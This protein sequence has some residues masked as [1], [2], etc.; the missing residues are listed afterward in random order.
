MNSKRWLRKKILWD[1]VSLRLRRILVPGVGPLDMG[2]ILVHIDP[3]LEHERRSHL[4]GLSYLPLAE[5]ARA[6]TATS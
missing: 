3:V 1:L 2:D 6:H 4:T 5:K